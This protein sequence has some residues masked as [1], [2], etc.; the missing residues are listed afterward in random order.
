MST[1]ERSRNIEVEGLP[2]GYEVSFHELRGYDSP[3]KWY[4]VR[5]EGKKIG[6]SAYMG[7]A[8][9]QKAVAAARDHHAEESRW[10]G[11]RCKSDRCNWRRITV[12]FDVSDEDWRAVRGDD[13]RC[14][15]LTCFDEEAQEKGVRYTLLG[16]HP[17]TWHGSTVT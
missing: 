10:L 12:G 3:D 14:R 11:E 5:R 7:Y 15:C 13:E 16:L 2:P 9:E 1:Y 4:E 8:T 17:V 6:S